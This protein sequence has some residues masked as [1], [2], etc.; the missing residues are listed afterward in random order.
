VTERKLLKLWLVQNLE[1]H[2]EVYW[3]DERLYLLHAN[4]HFH[5]W[6]HSKYWRKL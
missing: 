3:R 5:W 1:L 6:I 4:L 2:V